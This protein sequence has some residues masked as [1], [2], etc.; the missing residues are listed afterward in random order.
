L[1]FTRFN[2]P[3]QKSKGLRAACLSSF[4]NPQITQLFITK[5]SAHLHILITQI[6]VQ[7]FLCFVS[8]FNQLPYW[9]NQ[10][11]IQSRQISIFQ[12]G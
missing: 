12:G 1:L 4:N 9:V 7:F 2:S 8:F 11:K 10:R 6:S 5:H 3:G